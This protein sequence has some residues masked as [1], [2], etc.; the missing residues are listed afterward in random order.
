MKLYRAKLRTKN[1]S[2]DP[3]RGNLGRYAK[4]VVIRLGSSTETADI[5][6][7]IPTENVT[8]INT[9]RSCHNSGNKITMKTLFDNAG[10]KT[11][12]WGILG[13]S[14]ASWELFPAIIKH[15]NSCRGNGIYLINTKE[16]LDTF[17]AN[18]RTRLNE[19]IIEV[20]YT[21][22]KEYRLHVTENG[23]FY[24]CRKMLKSDAT[25]R[26]HRHDSNSVWILEDNPLFEKPKNWDIIVAECV[27]ALNA[28][29][30]SVGACD[31]KVQSEKGKAA[32]FNPDFIVL[33]INSA[34]SMGEVTLTKYLDEIPKLIAKKL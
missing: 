26:W 23:C 22:S 5:F 3:L 13:N 11:A 28:T 15:R 12:K 14:A 10:V 30:L 9:V 25:D 31:I 20:Y 18:N 27:K 34:P 6:P 4:P 29:G 24:T 2:A 1:S 7:N 32:S 33:E 16:E 19:H 8:E 17:V 21:F